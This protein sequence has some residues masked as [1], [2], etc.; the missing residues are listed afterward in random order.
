MSGSSSRVSLASDT[1]DGRGGVLAPALI[2]CAAIAVLLWPGHLSGRLDGAPL[3]QV[4]EAIL[5]GLTVP[6]LW[7]LYPGYLRRRIP[8]AL[9]AFL[10]LAK[11]GSSFLERDGWCV[12]FDTPKPLVTDSVGRIHSWDVRT[13]WYSPAPR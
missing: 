9:I 12:Q 6:F 5:L 8:Q 13:D 10:L 3:D 7:W 2:G 1:A 4:A 11:I